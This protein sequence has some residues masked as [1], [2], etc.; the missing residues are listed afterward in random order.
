MGD[1]LNFVVLSLSDRDYKGSPEDEH[2][3]VPRI[4]L[5]EM[6]EDLHLGDPDPVSPSTEMAAMMTE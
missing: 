3:D 5:Q 1:L 4:S 6:L 2:E